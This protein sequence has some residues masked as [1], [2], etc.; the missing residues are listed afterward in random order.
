MSGWVR[1]AL[2]AVGAGVFLAIGAIV[3]GGGASDGDVAA[4]RSAGFAEAFREGQLRYAAGY[5]DGVVEGRQQVENE[6]GGMVATPREFL[7][8]FADQ[9]YDAGYED[10]LAAIGIVLDCYVISSTGNCVP[11]DEVPNHAIQSFA[12]DQA[13]VDGAYVN[14][15]NDALD[16]VER[17]AQDSAFSSFILD[18]LL[19]LL[20]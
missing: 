15:W 6:F 2:I 5:D 13:Q 7:Q 12:E 9:E 20:L 19:S 8:A 18:L 11:F 14:G 17:Q 10:G 16:E 4:A 3:F 1:A